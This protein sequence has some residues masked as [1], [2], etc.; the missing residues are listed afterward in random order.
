MALRVAIVGAG[1][2]ARQHAR[3]CREVAGVA[4]AAVC[5]V[6]PE[7][8]ARLAEAFEVPAQYADLDA[9][10]AAAPLDLAIVATWGDSHAAVTAALAGSGRVRAILC[11]K[12]F[13]RTAAEAEAMRRAAAAGGVLLAEAF[14]FRHHPAHLRAAELVAAGAIGAVAHVRGVFAVSV[15]PEGRDPARNWR[16]NRQRGGGAIFDLGCYCTHH[17]R[18]TLGAEPLRVHAAVAATLE[19]SDGRT[20][21]WWVSFDAAPDQAVE[22]IGTAGRLRLDRAW[23][24]EDQPTA[25]EIVAG[26]GPARR[27]EFPPVFQFALQLE[28]LRDCLLTGRPHRI[29]TADSVAQM[30]ALDAIGE[31]LRTGAPVALPGP[32]PGDA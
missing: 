31:S 24:N 32:A 7:A 29:P 30:R 14:K 8:A 27:E 4:L 15:P 23:N 19:F 10:L 1:G 26:A 20:A 5:D 17:A 13:S 2:I 22:I 21:Q 9:L 25:L 11:E 3:A 18:W 16:F 12:P 6:R 28:H